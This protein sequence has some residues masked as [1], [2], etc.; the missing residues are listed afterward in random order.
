MI[1]GLNFARVIPHFKEYDAEFQETLATE[2]LVGVLR[3][4]LLQHIGLILNT[5]V[6]QVA[7]HPIEY[8]KEIMDS[9]DKTKVRTYWS[10][11]GLAY[12]LE[13][14]QLCGR[15]KGMKFISEIT[16]R[17]Y[18]TEYV[19]YNWKRN[20]DNREMFGLEGKIKPFEG[21]DPAYIP[22]PSRRS[23]RTI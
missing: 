9:I 10:K 11:E 5:H 19:T 6:A 12:E 13:E 2:H 14:A 21:V 8:V 4:S 20:P 18:R 22:S 3:G 7:S 1:K 16:S 15:C 17:G 23:I